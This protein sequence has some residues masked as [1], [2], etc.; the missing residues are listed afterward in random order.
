MGVI[1]EEVYITQT[2][3]HLNLKIKEMPIKMDKFYAAAFT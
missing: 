3:R 1:L 2:K